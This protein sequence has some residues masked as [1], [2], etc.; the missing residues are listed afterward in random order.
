MYVRLLTTIDHRPDLFPERDRLVHL[1]KLIINEGVDH[2]QRLGAVKEQLTGLAPEQYLRPLDRPAD[3]LTAGLLEL[4]TRTTPCCSMRSRPA[5]PSATARAGHCSSSPVGRCSACTRP[6][7]CSPPAG[8]LPRSPCPASRPGRVRPVARR[9]TGAPLPP[10]LPGRSSP[11]AAARRNVNWCCGRRRRRRSCSRGYAPL[12]W[13]RGPTR[14]PRS[15]IEVSIAGR[16]LA[17]LTCALL[18]A[19][20]GRAVRIGGAEPTGAR[21]L[22]LPQATVELLEDV[23][24][25]GLLDD[26]WPVQRRWVRWEA[27][28]PEQIS[29]RGVTLD[30]TALNQRLAARL[31]RDHADQ[32][33]FDDGVPGSWLVTAVPPTDAARFVTAGRRRMITTEAPLAPTADPHTCSMATGRQ[34]WAFLAPIGSRRALVQAMVPGPVHDPVRLLGHLLHETGLGAQLAGSPATATVVPAAPQLLAPPCGPG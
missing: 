17:A 11:S 21:P 8:W 3:Q 5:S 15:V 22:V 26:G 4:S 25:A 1:I 31:F 19:R 24:G 32:V 16:G 10:G 28:A 29:A 20:Q 7:T 6:T 27:A 14:D 30:G 18:V 12:R 2:F 23:W 34:A 13:T 9:W 33:R